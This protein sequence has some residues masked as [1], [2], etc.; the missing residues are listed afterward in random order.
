MDSA[1]PIYYPQ[2]TRI[3]GQSGDVSSPKKSGENNIQ[4]G[5]F[6]QSLEQA[7][8]TNSNGTTGATVGLKSSTQATGAPIGAAIGSQMISPAALSTAPVTGI[9]FSAHAAQRLRERSIQLDADTLSRMS[10]AITK[11]D[12]KGVQDTLV[13][14]NQA[15]LIVSVPNRT[16]ITAM[17][18]N[19]LSGNLFTNIDGAVII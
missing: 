14:T 8:K 17:D 6:D 2:V 1:K 18:R 19:N 5:E 11:A 10:D 15:A 16:V 7:L 9:K 3:P 4:P 12:A 13:L